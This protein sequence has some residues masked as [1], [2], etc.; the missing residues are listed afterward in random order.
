MQSQLGSWAHSSVVVLT[1]MGELEEG[2]REGVA[3]V[4]WWWLP[5]LL[6]VIFV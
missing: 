2:G 5:D 1:R 6:C 4:G 3:D